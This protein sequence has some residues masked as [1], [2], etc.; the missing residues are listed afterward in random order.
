MLRS[1]SSLVQFI[2]PCKRQ[3]STPG[4]E[5]VLH[6]HRPD[7]RRPESPGPAP[8]AEDVLRLRRFRLV[9]REHLPRAT[10][11]TSPG[12]SCASACRRHGRTASLRATMIGEPVAMPVA[13]APTGLTGMQHADGEI[14]AAR[15]RRSLRRAVHAL[16]HEHLLDRGRRRGDTSGPFWFQLYVMRDRDFVARLIERAKAAGCSALVLTLDLQILGQRHKDLRNGLSAP[17]KMTAEA[18]LA[19]RDPA[20]LG[21]GH[22]RHQ[23]PQLRQHRRPRRGRRR[24]RLAR[25]LDRPPVRSPPDL[26]RRRLDQGALGRQADPQGHPRPRGRAAGRRHRRRRASS[27]PTTAAASSTAPARRSRR[28]PASST[29]SATA[30]RCISTAASAPARTC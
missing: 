13:L 27:S 23:A 4:T 24:R 16:H 7:H 29:R 26:G 21:D 18:R 20:A 30:S 12:S 25:R 28:C 1:L 3:P 15:G 22:A 5:G 17:P 6:G 8:R 19:D 2:E 10:R 14:R 11:P 9:D